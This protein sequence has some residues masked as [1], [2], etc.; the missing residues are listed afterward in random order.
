ML[1]PVPHQ[2][3]RCCPHCCLHR[4]P[5]RCPHQRTPTTVLDVDLDL[6]LRRR[7][8]RSPAEHPLCCTTRTSIMRRVMRRCSSSLS[9]RRRRTMAVSRFMVSPV[10]IMVRLT[11][12]ACSLARFLRRFRTATTWRATLEARRAASDTTGLTVQQVARC[13]HRYPHPRPHRCPHPHPHP[14]PH[15]CPHQ[16]TPA[17]VLLS[18]SRRHPRPG[19]TPLEDSHPCCR[20]GITTTV[21]RR[22]PLSLCRRRT[23][24]VSRRFTRA[25]S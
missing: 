15:R 3:R 8:L 22:R 9:L 21:M 5:H 16:R 12:S 1:I 10:P 11:T 18:T 17:T 6:L 7:I 25:T 24:A 4:R 19:R 14:R 13:P 2:R 20:G 23:I